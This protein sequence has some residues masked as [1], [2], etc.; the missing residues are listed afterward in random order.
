MF[1]DDGEVVTVVTRRLLTQAIKF[2][3]R[4]DKCLNCCGD[5]VE[6]HQGSYTII[7]TVTAILNRHSNSVD[8]RGSCSSHSVHVS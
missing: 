5:Y 8:A 2:V 4:Y 7:A 1:K 6:K 3:P